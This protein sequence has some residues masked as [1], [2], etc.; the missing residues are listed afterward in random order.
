[1]GWGVVRGG[2]REDRGVKC[3]HW[4]RRERKRRGCGG[5]ANEKWSEREER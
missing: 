1:M 4:R 3:S 2:S 5:H